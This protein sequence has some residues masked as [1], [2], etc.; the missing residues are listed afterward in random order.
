MAQQLAEKYAYLLLPNVVV[1]EMIVEAQSLLF[2]TDRDSGDDRDF[3]PLLA[4]TMNRSVASRSPGLDHVGN[5]EESR[6]VREY[7][8]GAQPSSVFFT[9]VHFFCFQR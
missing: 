5:Q 3:V 7:Q 8:M 4:M 9:R 1:V 2:R 6:L